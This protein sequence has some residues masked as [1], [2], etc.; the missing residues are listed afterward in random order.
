MRKLTILFIGVFLIVAFMYA[1]EYL[2]SSGGLGTPELEAGR[3]EIEFADIDNDGDIDILSIGD[4]GSPYINTNEHGIMVWFGD[5]QGNWSVYQN[6]N[7][8]Y[9]GIAIGDLN[10]DGHM[11]V[12]YGMHHNYSSND[13]GDSI[14]EAALGDGTGQNWTAWD[15]GISTGGDWGMFSTD[16]ADINNDG[17]LDIGSVSFGADDGV[18]ICT[19]NGDGTWLYSFG[20]SGGNSTMFF[21]FGDINGDGNSDFVAGHQY[22]SIYLGD[23]AGNFT[24]ADGNLPPGGTLGRCGPSLGDVNNDGNQ[25]FA[26]SNSNGGIEVWVWNGSNTWVDYSG[27][28][29]SSGPYYGT[30]LCDLDIDGNIDVAAFGDSTVTVWSG[31]GAGNWSE[32]TT[33]F[34]PGPGDCEAFRVGGDADHNGYPDIALVSEEGDGWNPINHLHF[35]KETSSPGSLFI[36]PVFPRGSETFIA[37]SIHF[38]DWTC[39][40]PSGIALIDLELSTTGSSGPWTEIITDTPNNCRYQWSIPTGL[41]SDNCYIRYTAATTTDTNTAVTPASFRIS[42]ATSVDEVERSEL[43]GMSL[44]VH[45]TVS[46]KNIMLTITTNGT[47]KSWIKVYDNTGKVI[48]KLIEVKGS[49]NFNIKWD[50]KDTKRR[51]VPSGIYFI[52][53][54]T[55]EQSITKKI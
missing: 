31:D 14:L 41:S 16:F 3:T 52:S 13:F 1:L 54:E 8:G 18:H 5:G 10:N 19:N 7:F 32:A 46:G 20:F 9:G 39:G 37:G 2:E 25:D 26:Y 55:K 44:D 50:R 42:P 45:P 53:L 43:S 33:F 38:I 51:Y 22:G 36:F 35:Y 17:Y 40:V 23:G 6:G 34:T 12:G 11:D 48:R 15:D 49:G 29:P 28:L 27:T 47:T 21:T 4:H 30:Q 24:Q